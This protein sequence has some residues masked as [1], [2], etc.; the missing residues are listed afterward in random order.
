MKIREVVP[1]LDAEVLCCEDE[2]DVQIHNACGSD[3][4]SDVLAFVKDQT[5]LLTGLVN[6]QVVR[7]AMMMDMRCIVFVRGKTPTPEIVNLAKDNHIVVLASPLRMYEA[8]GRLYA[9]HL[10]EKES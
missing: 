7:T 1:L 4:M 8:C 5:A 2:L 6:P 9:N 3:M 10:A